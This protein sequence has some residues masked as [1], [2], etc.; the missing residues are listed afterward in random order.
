MTTRKIKRFFLL[1]FITGALSLGALGAQADDAALP[2]AL[3][4]IQEEGGVIDFM[5]HSYGVD[6]WRIVGTAGGEAKY[7]YTT[8]EGGLLMG[9]LLKP[10]GTS[11]TNEQLAALKQRKEGGQAALPGADQPTSST[12]KAEKVYA[13]IEKAGWARAG[14]TAAPYLYIFINALCDHC[15]SFWKEL[16][17]PMKAGKLQVRLIPFG[18][19]EENRLSGAALLSVDDPAAAWDAFMKGDK[20]VLAKDKIKEGMLA[21]IDAN[22]A[23][24]TEWKMQG[25]PFTV[26]RKP[27]DGQVTVIV[28]KPDNAMLVLADLMKA[29]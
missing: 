21:K 19:L 12:A 29:K 23:L 15:Q 1:C 2:P 14:D 16:E 26:Y 13:A 7:V 25:P 5:G 11:A 20:Q 24:F 3:K 10:D 6:G 4:K 28:G 27:S 22:T 18:K 8:P 17:G 9:V